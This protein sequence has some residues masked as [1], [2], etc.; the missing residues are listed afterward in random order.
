MNNLR[1]QSKWTEGMKLNC[2]E[3]IV[4]KKK[5]RGIEKKGEGFRLKDRN[6][7]RSMCLFVS[8]LLVHCDHQKAY[9]QSVSQGTHTHKHLSG[10]ER[11]ASR[12]KMKESNFVALSFFLS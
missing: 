2:A 12:V 11:R 5:K 6:Q 8:L 9:L 7:D 3:E 4:K 10:L 1:W